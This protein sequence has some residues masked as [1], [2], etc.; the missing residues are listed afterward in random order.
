MAETQTRRV[1]VTCYDGERLLVEHVEGS[2]RLRSYVEMQHA[3]GGLYVDDADLPAFLTA[4]RQVCPSQ[5][6]EFLRLDA[7]N[8]RITTSE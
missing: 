6:A 8:D 2:A 7:E 3:S 5:F 4:I 1:D